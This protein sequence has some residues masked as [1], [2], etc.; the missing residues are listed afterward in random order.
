MEI[1]GIVRDII[2]YEQSSGLTYAVA[3]KRNQMAVVYATNNLN[4]SFKFSLTLPSTNF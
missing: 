4:F 3:H 2:I 1:K